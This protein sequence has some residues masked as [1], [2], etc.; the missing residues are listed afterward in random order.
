[1]PATPYPLPASTR[2]S[3]ILL[4][5][6]STSYGPFGDGWGIFDEDDV[7]VETRPASPGTGVFVAAAV[8]IAKTS[9]DQAYSPFMVTFPAALTS[10]TQFRVTG[11]RLPRRELAISRGSALDTLMLERELTALVLAQ[12]E[13]RRLVKSL[14]GIAE[15]DAASQALAAQAAAEAA[16]AQII[17]LDADPGGYLT[18]AGNLA[19][20]ASVGAARTNLGLGSAAVAASSDF[21]TAAHVHGNATLADAGFMSAADKTKLDTYPAVYTSFTEYD[22]GALAQNTTYSQAHGL[23]ARPAQFRAFLEC[24]TA[25]GGWAVGDRVPV[26]MPMNAGIVAIYDNATDVGLVTRTT[27]TVQILNKSTRADFNIT[28]GNWKVIFRAWK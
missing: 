25:E 13:V 14:P 26:A 12:Q 15:G 21:A 7:L 8:T 17:L 11:D 2:Q 1:M 23:G 20:L 4:G 24:T 3:A 16:L 22:M 27:M 18:K 28:P 5:D 6:G 9:P 19:G 10:A